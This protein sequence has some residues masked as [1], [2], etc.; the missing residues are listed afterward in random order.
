MRWRI[1]FYPVWCSWN[2]APTRINCTSVKFN[3]F[4]VSPWIMSNVRAR[5]KRSSLLICASTVFSH[6]PF[7][8]LGIVSP[9]SV[10]T[11]DR[12]TF[13][14]GFDQQEPTNRTLRRNGSRTPPSLS[15]GLQHARSRTTTAT[16]SRSSGSNKWNSCRCRY[17]RVDSDYHSSQSPAIDERW[18]QTFVVIV[19][20]RVTFRISLLSISTV[21]IVISMLVDREANLRLVLF[22]KPGWRHASL[23]AAAWC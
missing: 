19:N 6:R 14:F 11:A 9:T 10:R 18:R 3:G 20:R 2:S 7:E 1:N 12:S 17:A 13:S 21:L 16:I 15:D 5:E 8:I 22:T 23:C 4:G